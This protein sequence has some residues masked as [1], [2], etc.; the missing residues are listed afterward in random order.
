MGTKYSTK[1]YGSDEIGKVIVSLREERNISQDTLAKDL[2]DILDINIGRSTVNGWENGIRA[3][4][5]THLVALADYFDVSTDFLLS[6]SEI[7]HI[8]K[9]IQT[10]VKTTGISEKSVK[11]LSEES[12]EAKAVR[13]LIDFILSRPELMKRIKENLYRIDTCINE[14]QP[15][16]LG[17][18]IL[19]YAGTASDQDFTLLY[20]EILEIMSSSEEKAEFSANRIARHLENALE[21]WIKEEFSECSKEV[22]R[23]LIEKAFKKGDS[24]DGKQHTKDN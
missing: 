22:R 7:S 14:S 2:K 1:P 15:E 24:S 10:A 6:R 16:E 19:D 5:S 4:N 3:I 20:S 8:N 11:F 23:I 9:E 13:F 12:E 18:N 17:I 21:E